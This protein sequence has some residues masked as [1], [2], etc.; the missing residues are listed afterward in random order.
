MLKADSG[1]LMVYASA[2]TS[3]RKRLLSVKSAAE[4]MAQQLNLGF[5]FVRQTRGCSPIYV[6]YEN[7]YDDPIPI[8]CDEGKKG[9]FADISSRLRNMIFV[10]SFHPKHAALKQVRKALVAL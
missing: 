1:R 4:K 2:E 7:G 8:Y 3:S 6:Y 5:E 10:L 9:D